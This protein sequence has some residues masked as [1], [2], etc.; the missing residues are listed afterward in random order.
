MR[1]IAALS[2]LVLAVSLA[3]THDGAGRA[4]AVPTGGLWR[5]AGNLQMGRMGHT[6]TLLPTG[7]VL[8]TG[9]GGCAAPSAS[10]WY[11]ASAELYDPATGRS[12]PTRAMGAAR[13]GQ[14]ATLLH[15]G[16]VLVVGGFG[17]PDSPVCASAAVYDAATGQWTP[18][19]ALHTG[20]F[21]HTATL[22]PDGAVLVVGGVLCAAEAC[23]ST[24]LYDPTTGRWR[25]AGSLREARFFH[26]ATVLPTGRVLVAGG[27]GCVP[28]HLCA[29]AELY[30][31]A[32][33]TWHATGRMTVARTEHTATLLRTGRVLV[34][35][36]YGCAP[37]YVC[38]SA[39]LYDPTTGTW[40]PTGPLLQAR[41]GHTATLLPDG[42]VLVAG[43]YGCD[44]RGCHHL[45]SAE[46]YD[47]AT[48]RW[49]S[50][51]AMRQAREYHTATLLANGTVLLMGGSSGCDATA[52]CRTAASADAYV[53]GP[54][55]ARISLLRPPQAEQPS[56]DLGVGCPITP[57]RVGI[58]PRRRGITNL[59]VAAQP[60]S[61]GIIGYLAS[62]RLNRANGW[63]PDGGT[64]KILWLDAADQ[65]VHDATMRDLLLG[66][67]APAHT[68]SNGIPTF[69]RPGCWQ[70]TLPSGSTV[71]HVVMLV[72]GD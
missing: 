37:T 44:R 28:A 18:T 17:C 8:V 22:L 6:A 23:R 40:Q 68:F 13:I 41:A 10:G 39:E 63:M 50:A 19:G 59:W 57:I 7:K 42:A 52:P 70:V 24:E 69:P 34:A 2:I 20:R 27:E 72:L 33:A 4:G 26:T 30:D 47:P 29:S 43:G 12:A 48:G 32:T 64:G 31:P 9:G 14:T 71:G 55:D 16:R 65:T 66:L 38:A 35:G 49:R 5:S 3:V 61:T 36:G 46:V 45:A 53:P 54:R 11:C 60:A 62:D 25:P 1:R 58:V 21:F 15:R 56:P 67:H 51:G